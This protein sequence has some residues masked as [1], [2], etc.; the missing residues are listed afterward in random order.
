MRFKMNF[1]QNGEEEFILAQPSQIRVLLNVFDVLVSL[2]VGPLKFADHP[3]AQLFYLTLVDFVQFVSDIIW[4]LM[5]ICPSIKPEHYNHYTVLNDVS[6]QELELRVCA[7]MHIPSGYNAL[8]TSGI[9]A[10]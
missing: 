4:S 2:L 1:R 7:V 6:K 3:D 9:P 10:V 5:E 8:G